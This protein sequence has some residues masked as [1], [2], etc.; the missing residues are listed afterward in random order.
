MK[1]LETADESSESLNTLLEILTPL[2]IEMVVY[3]ARLL[4]IDS[5]ESL[6]QCVDVIFENA[7]EN[8]CQ[9]LFAVLCTKLHWPCVQ[10]CKESQ[11]VVTFKEQ[12]KAT[13][14]KEVE[15]FLERQTLTKGRKLNQKIEDKDVAC[16]KKLR[17]PIALF[18]FIGHLYL[19]DFVPTILIKQCVLAH[20]DDA[21]C[22]E[23]SLE[24]L[25]AMLKIAG[26]KFEISEHI[27]L[28]NEFR[29]LKARKKT[30]PTSPHTRFMIEELLAM[31]INRW[32]AV[33]KVDYIM[34]YNLFL[35]DVEEKLFVIELWQ[36]RK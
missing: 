16:S 27:D 12:V 36:H 25:C 3:E 8:E 14:Q 2:N 1:P 18:R 32:D 11:R 34:L 6:E 29:L 33:N 17:R 13:A 21:F 35:G 22:N 7:I 26:K 10:I 9:E 24:T 23:N 19:I 30:T 4:K 20:L 28:T 5:V 31:Q 15:M